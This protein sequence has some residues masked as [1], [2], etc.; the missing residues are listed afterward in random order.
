MDVKIGSKRSHAPESSS[1]K[2]FCSFWLVKKNRFCLTVPSV[3][4]DFC[5]SHVDKKVSDFQ[6]T[7]ENSQNFPV[8]NNINN[9]NNSNKDDTTT[10]AT[11]QFW[12][13]KKN[14]FCKAMPKNNLQYCV[15][16]AVH[17][18]IQFNR[19]RIP[20]PYDS[21]HSCYED[22]LESHKKKCNS[23]PSLRPLFYEKGINIGDDEI[24]NDLKTSIKDMNVD[25]LNLLISRV[26]QLFDGTVHFLTILIK[27]HEVFSESLNDPNNG[28]NALKH[29]KQLSSLVGHMNDNNLLG[30]HTTY[31]EFGAGKGGLSHWVQL[32]NKSDD[33]RYILLDR[34]SVRY[35]ARRADQGPTFER[36][37][38]DIED[39]ALGKVPQLQG[40]THNIVG[41]GKHLCGRATDFM[42]RCLVNSVASIK[43]FN[44][45]HHLTDGDIY[46][47]LI[48]IG[49]SVKLSGIVL[50]LC[51][52]HRCDWNSYV[53]KEWFA[54]H[55]LDH[56][57]FQMLVKMSAWATCGT[58]HVLS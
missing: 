17:L 9:N 47:V 45:F 20:C 34:S 56:N 3:D 51:C 57:H 24:V 35:K 5:P 10:T 29:L 30:A 19:V 8:V 46:K 32:S 6:N 55:R 43:T 50:A 52:H 33:C 16:H 2:K 15:E 4:S 11:C 18:N 54:E 12:L 28:N 44:L 27:C 40:S 31:I 58:K 1:S 13:K 49:F 42:L 14:R 48:D 26:T 7:L 23:R 36:I 38:I 22:Q 21:N 39:L 53:G 25:D 37:K 41:I